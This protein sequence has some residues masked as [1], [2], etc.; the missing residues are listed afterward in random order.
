LCEGLKQPRKVVERRRDREREACGG[1]G[2]AG[3]EGVVDLGPHTAGLFGGVAVCAGAGEGRS[4]RVGS[5]EA[6]QTGL[7]A[8]FGRPGV[9]G[10]QQVHHS[11]VPAPPTA[12]S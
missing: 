8:Q 9:S 7:A 2:T 1:S 3:A 4:T 11:L 6:V 5:C 10:H 12:Y